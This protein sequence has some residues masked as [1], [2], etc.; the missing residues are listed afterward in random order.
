MTIGIVGLKGRG[1]GGVGASMHGDA[2]IDIS[3]LR[4][5]VDAR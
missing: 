4:G 2:G 3:L 1:R 5:G